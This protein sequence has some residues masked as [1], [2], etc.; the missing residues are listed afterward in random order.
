MLHGSTFSS[1]NTTNFHTHG[2]HVSSALGADNVLDVRVGPGQTYEYRIKIPADHM[3]GLFWY[4]PHLSGSVALQTTGGCAGVI[5]VRDPPRRGLPVWLRHIPTRTLV[6]Q[7]LAM[8]ELQGLLPVSPLC[9]CLCVCMRVC[10]YVCVSMRVCGMCH[11][12]YYY[13]PV[14]HHRHQ[15]I[16]GERQPRVPHG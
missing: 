1:P 13:H 10:V 16:L 7:Q 14:H 4:H 2:L 11:L 5:I 9:V 15:F 3:A 6:L 8:A 12:T